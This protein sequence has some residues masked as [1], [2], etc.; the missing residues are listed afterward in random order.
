MPTPIQ[1]TADIA[2]E[3]ERTCS[4]ALK[5]SQD[6]KQPKMNLIAESEDLYFG[7]VPKQLKNPFN[8]SF[9]FMSGFVDHYVSKIDDPPKITFSPGEEADFKAAQKITAAFEKI[10][11][12][13]LPHAKWAYKDRAAKTFAIFSGRGIN[14]IFSE[15]VPKFQVNYGAVDYYDF[16]CE[17]GGGGMLENHLF[18]GE[19]SLYFTK[20]QLLQG[21]QEGFYDRDQVHQLVSRTNESDMKDNSSHQ[22]NSANRHRAFG[23][24]PQSHNYTG[25]PTYKLTQFQ[26][27]YKGVRWLCLWD[28]LSHVWIRVKPLREITNSDLFTYTSWATNENAKFFWS[29]APCDDARPIGK[30]IN[31][32]LNQEL[33]NREKINRGQRAYDPHMFH[34]VEALGD[35]R[36]DGL[37]PVDT[38][39]QTKPIRE[40]IYT[41][42]VAGLNGT[43]DLVTYLDNFS[44]QKTG[45]TPGSQGAADKDK[46]VGI[47]FG[48]L[49][50]ID[51][52]IGTKN[53]SYREAWEETGIRFV[54]ML[55]M[56]LEDDELEIQLMGAKGT[57]WSTL[58]KKDLKTNRD[59]D[60]IIS[61]GADEEQESE[62]RNAKKSEALKNVKTPNPRWVDEEQLKISGYTE[63]ELKEA[64]ALSPENQ[65]LMA[66]AAQA[67]EEIQ[68]GREVKLN[69]GATDNF[70]Q[71]IID[72]AMDHDD[73]DDETF[74]RLIAYAEAHTEIAARNVAINAENILREQI[75]I[76]P[77]GEKKEPVLP[78][79]A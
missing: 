60:I 16:H 46:K 15:R 49:Q 25:Q 36:P 31:K 5:T 10:V 55:D 22:E 19:E 26:L 62:V 23:L 45:S 63:E 59:L 17:P 61:G 3:I 79:G 4:T 11:N 28:D 21:A 30:Y 37:I 32:A 42:E 6:Y 24:D 58:S 35:W 43:L 69:R 27:T 40:G 77:E 71:K 1:L 53:K 72:F 74:D 56:D 57:E 65:E 67:I 51:E 8:E 70:M 50:Q 47:F 14:R 44:G 68:K 66:E 54:N 9:P 52:F 33:Y 7:L 12:S 64:F 13:P 20:E 34:D 73:L 29:K 78:V 39:N 41:F 48:E 75:G 38:K 2:Q 18:C 76:S